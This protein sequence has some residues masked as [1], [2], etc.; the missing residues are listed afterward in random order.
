MGMQMRRLAVVALISGAGLSVAAPAGVGAE[1][2]GLPRQKLEAEVAKLENEA[3]ASSGL[4]SYGSLV[5][6]AGAVIAA[7]VALIGA[8]IT[9]RGQNKELSRQRDEDRASHD[10]AV[11]Q[12]EAE[13]ERD[14]VARF[15]AR[16]LD[17]GSD[18][19]AVQAGAV[20][21]LL[22]FLDQGDKAFHH[23]VR[24][25]LLAN[26]KVAHTEA[27]SKLLVRAFEQ[28]VST[29]E[30]PYD[31]LELDFSEARLDEARLTG[32]DL[33]GVRI[34]GTNLER[35]D[36]RGSQLREARGRK[37]ILS[38]ARIQGRE[39]SLFNARLAGATCVGTQFQGSDLVNVHLEGADLREARFDGARL[40]AAHL[41]KGADLRGAR[42]D[43][44]NVAD[45]YFRDAQFDDDAL[46]SL[47]LARNVD[48][49]H[50]STSDRRRLE[51]L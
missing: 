7:F 3:A 48:K 1:D 38:G 50:F 51:E 11:E 29:G 21:S 8:G 36:L 40:Q 15:S 25:V 28:A 31:A 4:R 44:A 34:R 22:S 14:L 45:T 26:L 35:A 41:E 43:G 33:T 2:A 16:L 30:V 12:R 32:L 46:G 27:V 49:A 9:I 42:F 23:Q 39:T 13:S 37:A 18:S 47:K 10:R 5:T 24:L 6:G 19:E 17:L 20:V